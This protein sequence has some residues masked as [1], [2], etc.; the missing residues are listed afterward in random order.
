MP[1]IEREAAIQSHLQADGAAAFELTRAPLLRARVL[2]FSPKEHVLIVVTHHIVCDESS[3]NMFFQELEVLYRAF[4]SGQRNQVLESPPGYREFVAWQQEWLQSPA[5]EAQLAFWKQELAGAPKLIELPADHARPGTQSYAAGRESIN[6]SR[7]TAAALRSLAEQEGCSLFMVVLAAVQA[8]L[9]RY[10]GEEDIVVGTPIQSRGVPAC[11]KTIGRFTNM[12]LL[13]TDLSGQ[14]T[15]RELLRRVRQVVLDAQAHKDMPF[16]KLLVELQPEAN[17]SYSPLFQVMLRVEEQTSVRIKQGQLEVSPIEPAPGVTSYDLSLLLTATPD[18]VKGCLEYATDLFSAARMGRMAEHLQSMLEAMPSH[19]DHTIGQVPILTKAER[20]QLVEEWN[21]TEM[22]FPQDMTIPQFIEA[23]VQRTP[24]AVAVVFE[25][26]HLTY[27][28]LD[29]RASQLAAYLTQLGV[30][31][32]TLV[33]LCVERSLAMIISALAILKAGGAYLPLDPAYPKDRL[34]FMCQDAQIVVLLTQ[35]KFA[36]DFALPTGKVVCVDHLQEPTEAARTPQRSLNSDNLAYVMYT[37]GS[38]GQ[39]K[40]VMV[41][42]RNVA[43]FFTAMDRVIGPQP[44]VWLAVTSISF[45][46]S[47]LELFWTLARGFKVVIHSIE[48][49][50]RSPVGQAQASSSHSVAGE[51]SVQQGDYYSIPGLIRRHQVTHFQCTPSHASLLLHEPGCAQA[52]QKLKKVL[53]GGEALSASLLQQLEIEGE[54]INVYGPTET[55]VWSTAWPV[56][57]SASHI[58]IGRPI[59]NTQIYILD[60]HLSPTPLGI[61]GEI[62]IGGAGVTRGYL[63]RPELTAQRFIEDPFSGRPGARLYRTGDLAR[64]TEDGK[65]EF[66]GRADHQIKVR[67]FR[68]EPGEIESALLKHPEVRE[69]VVIAADDPAGQKQVLAYVVPEGLTTP[70]SA[71]LRQFLREKLPPYMVPSGFVLLEKLPLT[72]SGKIN[73]KALPAPHTEA[74]SADQVLPRSPVETKLAQIWCETLGLKQVGIHDNF[75]D[76]GGHSL[77][78][79]WLFQKIR[80]VF[81]KHLPMVTLFQSPTIAQLAEV[82]PSGGRRRLWKRIP[83]SV[84]HNLGSKVPLSFGQERLWFIQQA[85]PESATYN[86]SNAWLLCGPLNLPALQRSLDALVQRHESFRTVFVEQGN[87]PMQQVVKVEGLKIRQVDLESLPEEERERHA[88]RTDEARK[89]PSFRLNARTAGPG[90]GAATERGEA[91]FA[92][93]NSPHHF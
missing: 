50:I 7:S 12:L 70:S 6:L 20:D 22:A 26:K 88:I 60:A 76:L 5:Q 69:A 62:F 16:E 3:T 45:D 30:G 9:F 82:T 23:Q 51:K 64:W 2:R 37:S 59:A 17:P 10:T 74:E 57:K 39:P 67:G 4:S 34:A 75:F 35:E 71:A 61:P 32:E 81:G 14:P 52:F 44:G 92:A 43:N 40:G 21:R 38:T 65:I 84:R 55:T 11:E 85:E 68:I 80:D 46:I 48:S 33:G 72:S 25:D 56:D 41:T 1:E 18:G 91:L 24:E 63:K 90:N 73:R 78:A 8:L 86:L 66:L 42:H 28:E 27:Q 87:Q 89:Q 77:K 53:V 36:G 19:A 93:G 54:I 83:A 29:R 47:V 31:P 13:R 49:S 79:V 15:V 58:S